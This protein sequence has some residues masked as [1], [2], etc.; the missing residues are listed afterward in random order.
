M[1]GNMA[2]VDGCKR[3]LCA[4]MLRNRVFI[5]RVVGALGREITIITMLIA[6]SLD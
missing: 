2:Q 3:V 1:R 5:R 6:A 4:V